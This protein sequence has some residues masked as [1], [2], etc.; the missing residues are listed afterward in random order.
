MYYKNISSSVKTFYGVTFNPGE[1]REVNNYINHKMMI[2]VDE[3]IKSREVIQQ[4]PSCEKPKKDP[5]EEQKP[6]EPKPVEEPKPAEE[7]KP[8]KKS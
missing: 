2:E 5:K 4:K 3:P 8:E 7:A 6:E 1:I